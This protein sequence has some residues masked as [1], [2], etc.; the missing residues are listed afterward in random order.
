M[1]KPAILALVSLLTITLAPL[2]AQ[3]SQT[4]HGGDDIRLPAPP[5]VE[6][7]P[8]TDNYYGTKLVDNYRWLEDAKSPA[9]RTF[10]DDENKYTGQYFTQAHL[11]PH[12]LDQL[13]ALMHVGDE[14]IPAQRGDNYFF[15][16]RLSDEEQASIYIR[17]GWAGKDERTSTPEQVKQRSQHFSSASATSRATALCSPPQHPRRRRR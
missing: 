2:I 8:V 7:Q 4:I 10:I 9:T 13:D 15:R 1:R 5:Q 16:K 3:S 17:R 6:V 14:G 12:V 11:R